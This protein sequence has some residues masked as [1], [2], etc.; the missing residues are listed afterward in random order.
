[1]KL[2]RLFAL[3][4]CA[5]ALAVIPV[6]QAAASP[7]QEV[8]AQQTADYWT[9]ERIKDALNNPM[10]M[11]GPDMSSTGGLSAAGP[12]ATIQPV[13]GPYT[14]EKMR[15]QGRLLFTTGGRNSSCSATSVV[16]A[17]KN[18][19]WTAAH[20]LQYGGSTSANVTFLPAYLNNARPYGTWP[21]AKLH[22]PA[23]WTSSS[24]RDFAYDYAAFTVTPQAGKSLTDTVGAKSIVFN[25]KRAQQSTLYGYPAESPYTGQQSYNCG[26]QARVQ[27]YDATLACNG[28]GG[29]SGGA[30][31]NANDQIW[32]VNSR[33]DRR[34]TTWGTLFDSNAQTFYNQVQA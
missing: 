2:T 30:W 20:C 34:T 7:T 9:P 31:L 24:Q 16:A 17:N 11:P 33:S 18:L 14:T 28:I 19:V 10:P 4:A 15:S 23:R 13:P 8:S 21:A 27:T 26:G 5:A 22:I 32:A 12:Q 1:M 25:D 29:Q 3:G 6:S